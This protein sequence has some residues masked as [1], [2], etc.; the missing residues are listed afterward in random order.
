MISA[1]NGVYG[2]LKNHIPNLKVSHDTLHAL[3]LCVDGSV[4]DTTY[5][6]VIQYILLV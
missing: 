2:M 3:S 6:C 1:N 4:K 5:C